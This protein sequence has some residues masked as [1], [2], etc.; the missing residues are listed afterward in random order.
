MAGERRLSA[1]AR[2]R[3]TYCRSYAYHFLGLRRRAIEDLRHTA[4]NLSLDSPRGYFLDCGA[5][6]PIFVMGGDPEDDEAARAVLRD[7]AG[8]I[9]GVKGWGDMLARSLWAGSHLSARLGD[10]RTALRQIKSAWI[11]LRQDGMARELVAAT[12]DRCQLICR[13][14][15]HRADSPELALELIAACR[16]PHL[17]EALS[18]RLDAMESVLEVRPEH[19]FRELVD[20]RRSFVAPVPG[21]MAERIGAP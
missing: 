14:V 17:G 16:R 20:C 9:H 18:E 1:D 12:L 21:A 10:F 13:G 8:R 4:M 2:A 3:I 7:F 5:L 11:R 6:L 19:A 15:E